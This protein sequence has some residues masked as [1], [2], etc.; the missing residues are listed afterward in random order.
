MPLK[1][2]SIGEKY[3]GIQGEGG[4]GWDVECRRVFQIR[5]YINVTF[6]AGVADE[7]GDEPFAVRRGRGRV[8]G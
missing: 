8:R 1:D 7:V 5:T 3:L 4:Q 2:A 6:P